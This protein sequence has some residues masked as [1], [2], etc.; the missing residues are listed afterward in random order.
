M[1]AL[2]E[3]RAVTMP[4][5]RTVTA[6]IAIVEQRPDY[7]R[8][9]RLEMADLRALKKEL[10]DLCFVQMFASFESSLR[11]YWRTRVRAT[12]PPTRQLLLSIAEKRGIEEETVEDVQAIRDLR[13]CLIHEERTIE[14]Q[15]S[16]DEAS[17]LLSKYLARLP[18]EW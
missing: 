2:S 18:L 10:H 17:R 15:F 9:H 6:M 14:R 16:I 4:L 11:N 1:T 8:I 12:K 5:L 3:P 13:N 7:L